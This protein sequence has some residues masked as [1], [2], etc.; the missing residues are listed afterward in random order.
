MTGPARPAVRQARATAGTTRTA[1]LPRRSVRDGPR[2]PPA[3]RD[4][5]GF[6]VAV[7]GNP[8]HGGGRRFR[9]PDRPAD[10]ADAPAGRPRSGAA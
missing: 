10:H 5:G 7:S 6:A 9:V 1:G 3:T 4:L 8:L 2:P